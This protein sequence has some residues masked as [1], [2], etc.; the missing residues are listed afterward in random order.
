MFSPRLLGL[1]LCVDL[2][3]SAWGQLAVTRYYGHLN[4]PVPDGDLNGVVNVQNITGEPHRSIAEIAVD[5]VL[6]GVDDEEGFTG[7]LY[8]TLLHETDYGAGYAVLLNRPGRSAGRPLGYSDPGDL[9][10][11]LTVNAGRDIHLYRAELSSDGSPLPLTGPLTGF[12]EP[13]GRETDPLSVVD[14]DPRT[15]GLESFRGLDPNGRWA[16]Y[17]ADVSNG[18]AVRLDGWGLTLTLVPEPRGAMLVAGMGMLGWALIR[19]CRRNRL[20]RERT[21]DSTT[22]PATG[23]PVLGES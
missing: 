14:T 17:V 8:I 16:L 2:I 10:V 18:G 21:R 23:H 6:G 11:T 4:Q 13:D 1:L 9:A 5:L 7:D 15:A 12:W 19:R 22:S 3:G 20:I